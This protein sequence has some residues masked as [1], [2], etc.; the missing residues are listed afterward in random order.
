VGEL[1][2]VTEV[3]HY[4]DR[5]F[6]IR[7]ERPLTYRFTAGEFTMIGL[8]DSDVSRAY[9]FTS[10]PGDDYLEF[11]S[12][13]VPNGPLT[14]RL[15]HVKPGDV[16]EVGSKATGTL[17]L[18][19]LE[20]GG[21]LWMFATGTG[22]APFISMLRDM[23]TYNAFD[24]IYLSWTVRE[25]TDL[26]SYSA[27]LEEMSEEMNFTYFPTVTRDLLFKNHG[28]IQEFIDLGQWFNDTDPNKDKA[29]ICGSIDFNNDIAS[30][31]R[32][33]GWSEGTKKTAGTFVQER[34]FVG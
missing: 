34:A 32:A 4:T 14:S 19:N 10:G 30:M 25:S 29:M 17:T 21:N 15:Q 22:V 18:A 26:Q 5:L 2:T 24:H 23:E 3:E 12:I 13:K 27:F 31:L 33:A 1:L 7:T 9:S 28:R 20:L 6:R 8:P 11:Y 16:L